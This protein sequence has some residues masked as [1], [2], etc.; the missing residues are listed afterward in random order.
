[1]CESLAL[2]PDSNSTAWPKISTDKPT[3]NQGTNED[4]S[5]AWSQNEISTKV[6]A[7]LDTGLPI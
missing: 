7:K 4:K 5:Y 6:K 2:N 3:A 1:V